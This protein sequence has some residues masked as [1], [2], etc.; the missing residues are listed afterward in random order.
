MPFNEEIGQARRRVMGCLIAAGIATL[1]GCGDGP[2]GI[3]LIRRQSAVVATITISGQVTNTSNVG[4]AGV[5]VALNGTAQSVQTTDGAGSYAFPQLTAGSYSVQPRLNGCAFA[6][7]V[8][9]LNN[10]T[11]NVVQNFRGIGASCIGVSG[12]GG[13]TGAGGAT[14]VGG[15]TGL[16]GASGG[17]TLSISIPLPDDVG[18]RDTPVNAAASLTLRD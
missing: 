3:P 9:N 17:A 4:I 16:G 2:T 6:P 11:A 18:L 8:V 15:A 1:V 13:A 10:L 14:G 5:T 7:D 12:S